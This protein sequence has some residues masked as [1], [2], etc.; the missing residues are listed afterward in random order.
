MQQLDPT[1]DLLSCEQA[2]AEIG[3]SLGR[4]RGLNAAGRIRVIII[5]QKCVRVT[6]ADL[7]K[8][9]LNWQP[10]R[11]PPAPRSRNGRGE[12]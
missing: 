9:K 10:A 2:S 5:N 11:N 12:P 1:I 4:L 3:V 8:L 6:R 7:D